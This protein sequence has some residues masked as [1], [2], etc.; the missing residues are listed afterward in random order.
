MM[1]VS[2][3]HIGIVAKLSHNPCV[4]NWTEFSDKDEMT[5]LAGR[6][7]SSQKAKHRNQQQ[8]KVSLSS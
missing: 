3:T 4:A 2:S 6:Y 1:V 5:G 8:G 7:C